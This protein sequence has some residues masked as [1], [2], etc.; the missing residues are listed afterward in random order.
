MNIHFHPRSEGPEQYVAEAEIHFGQ[1][2]PL[3]DGTKLAGF[4]LWQRGDGRL[5]VIVPSRSWGVGSYRQTVPLLRAIDSERPLAV[6]RLK[7]AVVSAW[8]AYKV[9]RTR[10]RARE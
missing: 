2:T 4:L 3:L 7:A 10:G 6:L 8:Q 1:E 5:E 9:A